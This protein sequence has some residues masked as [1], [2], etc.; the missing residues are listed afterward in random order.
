MLR[1]AL[2]VA[3][4][5]AGLMLLGSCAS[6]HLASAQKNPAYTGPAL[7]RVMVIG[8]TNDARV[9]RAFEDKFVAQL[10][11]VG[12]AAVA[13]YPSV[14]KLGATELA[15]LWGVVKGAGVDGVMV[16]RED[17]VEQERAAFAGFNFEDRTSDF[18][19]E[20]S[21]GGDPSIDPI[22]ANPS[23]FITV[24]FSLYSVAGAQKVWSGITSQMPYDNLFDASAGYG[25]LVIQALQQQKLI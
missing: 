21:A 3:F 22:H 12:V 15:G 14:P 20:E 10:K 18:N 8:V 1:P 2:N 7:T 5:A 24:R 11:A 23:G 13:S 19:E 9:R 4:A 25:A 16:A 17:K 6:V